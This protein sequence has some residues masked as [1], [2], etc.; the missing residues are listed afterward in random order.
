MPLYILREIF[1][2]IDVW[3]GTILAQMA[4][5]DTIILLRRFIT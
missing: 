4:K 5:L 1:T 3:I 2:Y